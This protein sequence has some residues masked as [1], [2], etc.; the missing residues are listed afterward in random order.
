MDK[1]KFI[2]LCTAVLSLSAFLVGCASIPKTDED[3]WFRSA[4]EGNIKIVRR[5]IN[6]GVDVDRRDDKQTTALMRASYPGHEK[7]VEILIDNGADVNARDDMGRT[8]LMYASEAGRTEVAQL[9]IENGANVNNKDNKGVTA[10]IL[11][12]QWE[13]REISN[14]LL[15]RGADVNAQ[16]VEGYT[17]LMV[18][19][20]WGHSDLTATLL[21]GGADVNVQAKNGYTALMFAST[22]GHIKDIEM[23]LKAGADPDATDSD[24]FTALM[25]AANED[26][27]E[28][29]KLLLSANADVN[30]ESKEGYTALMIALAKGNE[31]MADLLRKRMLYLAQTTIESTF[32]P[33]TIEKKDIDE[34][35]YLFWAGDVPSKSYK[36]VANENLIIPSGVTYIS[37]TESQNEKMVH[38]FFKHLADSSVMKELQGDNPVICGPYLT[39][40]IKRGK[41]LSILQH[42][43][44][45]MYVPTEKPFVLVCCAI[46]GDSIP[47]ALTLVRNLIFSGETVTVRSLNE[48]E[49]DWYWGIISWD[50]EEPIFVFDSGR[51]K[52]MIDFEED[53]EIFYVDIL[54]SLEWGID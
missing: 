41:L 14:L 39:T 34:V 30:A 16:T 15:E 11:S 47:K 48:R 35:R 23:L 21:E 6:E 4:A 51:H 25:K 12:Q 24:G 28:T 36:M 5:L 26:Q 3:L 13:R 27:I 29:A 52:V 45:V 22:G 44:L 10:L 54:D 43:T 8:A 20:Q 31:K 42:A 1:T 17:A 40:L 2:A 33:F 32:F 50:I 9:L 49:L 53:G 38:D 46:N 7:I 37:L 18:S 19:A